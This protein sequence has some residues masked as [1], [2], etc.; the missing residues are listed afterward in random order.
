[1]IDVE[2]KL[3][4]RSLKKE[5]KK[6]IFVWTRN[7]ERLGEEGNERIGKKIL[8]VFRYKVRF[9]VKNILYNKK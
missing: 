4:Y 9:K 6:T 1:M 8:F 2:N 3:R 7:I 5:E